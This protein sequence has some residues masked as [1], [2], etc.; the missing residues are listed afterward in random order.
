MADFDKQRRQ[1]DA[2]KQLAKGVEA[3]FDAAAREHN[4][5]LGALRVFAGLCGV[6]RTDGDTVVHT[7]ADLC[8]LSGADV[9]ETLRSHTSRLTGPLG[10]VISATLERMRAPL[11][12]GWPAS[13]LSD[14]KFSSAKASKHFHDL[15][16]LAFVDS[17]RKTLADD[18]F[19]LEAHELLVSPSA[20]H[21]ADLIVTSCASLA[22]NDGGAAPAA[23]AI[24]SILYVIDRIIGVLMLVGRSDPVVAVLSHD[25]ANA[26]FGTDAKGEV[27]SLVV[28]ALREIDPF[29]SMFFATD[30]SHRGD[31]SDLLACKSLVELAKHLRQVISLHV[32]LHRSA[33]GLPPVRLTTASDPV[34]LIPR[35]GDHGS[36]P[37]SRQGG[38]S[39]AGAGTS[40]SPPQHLQ[41]DEILRAP[42]LAHAGQHEHG[43]CRADIKA[44]LRFGPFGDIQADAQAFADKYT[45]YANAGRTRGGKQPSKRDNRP[46]QLN[47]TPSPYPSPQSPSNVHHGTP[48][49]SS[50]PARPTTT[51]SA[52]PTPPHTASALANPL[53]FLALTLLHLAGLAR[54]PMPFSS[55]LPPLA[56][57][58]T[59]ITPPTGADI[60]IGHALAALDADYGHSTSFH[61]PLAVPVDFLPTADGSSCAGSSSLVL[62]TGAGVSLMSSAFAR[63]LGLALRTDGASRHLLRAANGT[64]IQVAGRADVSL[65]FGGERITFSDVLVVDNLAVDILVGT[66]HLFDSQNGRFHVCIKSNPVRGRGPLVQLGN[67]S[68]VEAAATNMPNRKHRCRS[69]RAEH[70]PPAANVVAYTATLDDY[71]LLAHATPLQPLD[72]DPDGVENRPLTLANQIALRTLL[73]ADTT[74]RWYLPDEATGVDDVYEPT[75]PG[76]PPY[77]PPGGADRTAYTLVLDHIAGNASIPPAL[78]KQFADVV[79]QHKHCFAGT[80]QDDCDLLPPVSRLPPMTIAMKPGA[81]LDE[82][83]SNSTIPLTGDELAL[84]ET[85]RDYLRRTHRISPTTAPALAPTFVVKQTTKLRMVHNYNKLN[86]LTIS[87]H[88]ILPKPDDIQLQLA[89]RR[90][91]IKVDLWEAF[92]S[93]PLDARARAL[94][95]ARFGDETYHYNVVPTGI[96]QAPT[97]LQKCMNQFVKKQTQRYD[98]LPYIDD[99]LIGADTLDDLLVA[100]AELMTTID[101]LQITLSAPKTVI[102][103]AEIDAL[104]AVVSHNTVTPP[105]ERIEA[106]LNY[107]TPRTV[108]ELRGFLGLFNQVGAH[109]AQVRR[110]LKP[111]SDAASNKHKSGTRLTWSAEMHAAF[112][113]AKAALADVRPLS[114]FDPAKPVCVLTDASDCGAAAFLCQIAD[115]NSHFVLLDA[116]SHAFDETERAYTTPE[117]EALALR[118]GA[119]RWRHV[120]LGR[121][122]IWLCDNEPVVNAIRTAAVS[123]SVRMRNTAAD[124]SGYHLVVSHISGKF[125]TAADA[126]SRDPRFFDLPEPSQTTP[127]PDEPLVL[128][129]GTDVLLSLVLNHD[130][131]ELPRQLSLDDLAIDVA[132]Q[133]RNDPT[134]APLFA[135]ATPQRARQVPADV[136]AL[137]PTII[138]GRL[139]VQPTLHR[140]L[141]VPRAL[142]PKAIAAVHGRTHKDFR[143][144]TELAL[145]HYYW[146]DMEQDIKRQVQACIQCQRVNANRRKHPGNLG[147]PARAGPPTRYRVWDIDSYHFGAELGNYRVISAVEHYSRLAVAAIVDDG[148]ASTA[149]DALHQILIV[150]F[151]QPRL[152]YCD[153]GREFMA[154]VRREMVTRGVQVHEGLPEN[155]NTAARVE[156]FHEDIN[157]QFRHFAIS[158]NGRPPRDLAEAK[159]WLRSVL[160]ERNATPNPDTHL[161]PQELLTGYQRILPMAAFLDTGTIDTIA[162]HDRDLAASLYERHRQLHSL[163]RAHDALRDEHYKKQ[164]EK[165][166]ISFAREHGG[167]IT[168]RTGSLVWVRGPRSLQDGQ[169]K[170]QRQLAHSGPFRVIDFDPH[171]LRVRVQLLSPLTDVDDR[172]IDH[173]ET[174]HIRDTTPYNELDANAA[175]RANSPFMPG[176][177]HLAEPLLAPTTP[178]SFEQALGRTATQALSK[179]A[180]AALAAHAEKHAQQAAAEAEGKRLAQQREERRRARA[181]AIQRE[182]QRQQSARAQSAQRTAQWFRARNATPTRSFTAI[183]SVSATARTVTGTLDRLV[184]GQRQHPT[185]RS[186]DELTPADLLLRDRWLHARV[187]G[188]SVR[189]ARAS[190][191]ADLPAASPASCSSTS[192]RSRL[193]RPQH[194]PRH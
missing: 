63:R 131:Y 154:D 164:R 71:A 69:L 160:D 174:V 15:V 128:E 184:P 96:K 153:P 129:N 147:N 139:Y 122:V 43:R 120:M 51:P 32:R 4:P 49:P 88:N 138:D 9:F 3:V 159:Q 8:F 5:R 40:Q 95:A 141:V 37:P 189:D 161:S 72:D 167:P 175:L 106:L 21:I 110:E 178:A 74:H 59:R 44:L 170:T 14:N 168:L 169:G 145:Q 127:E 165:N 103:A 193:S 60:T 125:H 76:L 27:Y 142:V 118:L 192:S 191:N 7:P 46:K 155:H 38:R 97:H 156:R 54:S 80:K 35:A 1:S 33:D 126:L 107:G 11:T 66:R 12:N 77:E 150:P 20:Y 144:S 117:R 176:A 133:Q 143:R 39:G 148:R 180:K 52:P 42:C 17:F 140:R 101:D 64:S 105:S 19:I 18:K 2:R 23:S 29:A 30:A 73:D 79:R 34:L 179:R 58:F 158:N 68:F 182:Q 111:L 92:Y 25:V 130:A 89:R 163:L 41:P 6:G 56:A 151:G 115:D 116:L 132:T 123:P 16:Q 109:A 102:A 181:A 10:T 28:Q 166:E 82:A 162:P 152:I 187:N 113:K 31:A 114:P 134:L 57:E 172:N 186:Y 47:D 121:P 146:Q 136:R 90:H 94:T 48:L 157:R 190:V 135:A 149:V 171:T 112:E 183:W 24:A 13:A 70:R 177:P 185:T 108:R 100:F 87:N 188:R 67:S 36:S 194:T 61:R 45:D 65:I 50:A 91:F 22:R 173:F 75:A 83:A 53:M 119:K 86:Q 81:D 55:A 137:K 78:R 84:M 93:M 124:L 62:D 104:G 99:I 26:A 85:R 98:V